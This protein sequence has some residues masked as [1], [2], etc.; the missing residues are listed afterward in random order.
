MRDTLNGAFYLEPS[1]KSTVT[2]MLRGLVR[3]SC[4]RFS[5]NIM[6]PVIV[7]CGWDKVVKV[8]S[9]YMTP[10]CDCRLRMML[11][12]IFAT[13]EGPPDETTIITK[14]S[15][16]P[17][18]SAFLTFRVVSHTFTPTGLGTVKIQTQN[19]PL[20]PYRIHQRHLRLTRRLACSIRRQR[21]YHHALGSQRGQAP[22]FARGR[23]RRQRARIL[24]EPV[25]V[26]RCDRELCQN[27]RFGEQVSI[28][29]LMLWVSRV[30]VS[31]RSIVDEL[32]P[33]FLDS[34]EKS[35]DPECVSI[36]WSADGQTL[37]CGF[38]DNDVRVWTV[39]T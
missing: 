36:A 39:S 10:R 4:V 29:A 38:T 24:S 23:R 17:F 3:V 37:F 26:V 19:Q 15:D 16:S 35:R 27:F 8:R 31:L 13:S 18:F 12:Y 30:D 7:S 2:L 14:I 32:K 34:T 9:T 21:R 25:L 1:A 5:P 28:W 6:N 22:L 33:T 11:H 20:R